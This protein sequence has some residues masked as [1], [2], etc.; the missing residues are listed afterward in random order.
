MV[1]KVISQGEEA[2]YFA[3]AAQKMVLSHFNVNECISI[4][5]TIENEMQRQLICENIASFDP[6]INSIVKVNNNEEEELISSAWV[7][8]ISLM[9]EIPS[10]ICWQM[11][12]WLAIFNY[13]SHKRHLQ[14]FMR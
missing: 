14:F 6:S 12:H 10:L 4:I 2:I 7:S 13:K 8:N 1:D 3:N 9:A 11:K 5:V